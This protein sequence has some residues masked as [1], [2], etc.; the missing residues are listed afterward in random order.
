MVAGS[1]QQASQVGLMP[2]MPLDKFTGRPDACSFNIDSSTHG[3]PGPGV[4]V[5][6]DFCHSI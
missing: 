4:H 6:T 3:M 2:D 5:I 1:L